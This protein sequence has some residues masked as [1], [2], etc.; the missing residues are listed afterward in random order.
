MNIFIGTG[1]QLANSR[2]CKT[3]V[4]RSECYKT[5]VVR[6]SCK[7]RVLHLLV[8]PGVTKPLVL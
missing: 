6:S 7:K 4:V 5:L 1:V 2:Y 8:H 3:L